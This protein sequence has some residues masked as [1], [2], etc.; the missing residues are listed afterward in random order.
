MAKIQQ[1]PRLKRRPMNRSRMMSK[2]QL[3]AD[4]EIEYKNISLLQRFLNERGKI[5]PRRISGITAR[6]QRQLTTAIKRARFLALLITGTVK[7]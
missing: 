1:K 6:Q 3:P 2:F 4:L 5:V 7:K